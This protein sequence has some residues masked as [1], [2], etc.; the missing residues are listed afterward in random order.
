[1]MRLFFL[2]ITILFLISSCTQQQER[3]LVF[4][5]T[6]GFRHSSIEAG[7][8][9][10]IK[11]GKENNFA[12][13]TTE[14][15]GMFYASSLKK[16]KAVIFLNTTGDVL[17]PYQKKDF[18]KFIQ[19]GGGFVGV[20]AAT[21]TEYNWPWYGKMVGAYFLDHPEIQ[22]ARLFRAAKHELNEVLPEEWTR[23]DEWYNFKDI[24]PDINVLLYI[25]ESSYNGGKNGAYHPISW[26]HNY[27]GGRAFYTAMGHTEASYNEELFLQHLLAGI[28]YAMGRR[29]FEMPLVL[30]F[31]EKSIEFKSTY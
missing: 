2:S 1:M 28:E 23:T 25:D 29:R 14:D 22:E 11:L 18:E 21:D 26:W 12:A 16:Y 5:K 17:N 19:S 6:S 9:A 30:G 15:A 13:D 8:Q 10:I 7:K 3:V 20:H 31:N 4:S 24:N 27:D